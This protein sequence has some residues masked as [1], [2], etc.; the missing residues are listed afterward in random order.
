MWTPIDPSNGLPARWLV[1]SD[2][3]GG[4]TAT[5]VRDVLVPFGDDVI[6]SR[7][8]SMP[9][10]IGESLGTLAMATE[11]LVWLALAALGMAALGLYSISS[12]Q[13]SRQRQAIGIRIALGAAPGTVTR[14]VL[15]SSLVT[16]L[17]GAATGAV[18]AVFTATYLDRLLFSVG[19]ADPIAILAAVCGTAVV[20]VAAAAGPARRAAGTDP[21]TAMRSE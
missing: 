15:I 1:R 3:P 14:A 11:L 16:A 10:L 4:I 6:I 20:A 21:L 9:A 5:Q 8:D 18:G 7:V 19:P 2:V 17:A 12:L 13:V